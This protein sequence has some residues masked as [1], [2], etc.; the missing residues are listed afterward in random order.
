[1]KLFSL[2]EEKKKEYLNNYKNEKIYEIQEI[3]AREREE[4]I[5]Y[6]YNKVNSSLNAFL[7]ITALFIL[8][9]NKKPNFL[10]SKSNYNFKEEIKNEKIEII[11][12]TLNYFLDLENINNLELENL[13]QIFIFHLYTM[14]NYKKIKFLFENIEESELE[15]NLFEKNLKENF[16]HIIFDEYNDKKENKKKYKIFTLEEIKNISKKPSINIFESKI[17]KISDKKSSNIFNSIFNNEKIVIHKIFFEKYDEII[18]YE[19]KK[20]IT[21]TKKE[22]SS[23]DYLNSYITK[24]NQIINMNEFEDS[25]LDELII[26]IQI[27]VKEN[28]N[29]NNIN[30]NKEKIIWKNEKEKEK[31]FSFIE[32]QKNDRENKSIKNEINE[33]KISLS[34]IEKEL[35]N[36]RIIN[37]KLKEEINFLKKELDEMKNKYNNKEEIINDLKKQLNEEKINNNDLEKKLKEKIPENLK[38]LYELIFEKDKEISKLKNQLKKFPFKLNK[39]EKLISI[40]ITTFDED[41]SY[42]MICKNTDLFYKIEKEF[43]K[44]YGEYSKANN[45]FI[46]KNNIINKSKSLLENKI[47][48]HDQIILKKEKD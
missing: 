32:G 17:Q 8:F 14:I 1:M 34:K 47:Y 6:N 37:N 27:K 28:I 33:E 42:S 10:L 15:F 30:E 18:R 7:F 38:E 21:E 29:K 25:Y 16:I 23:K 3:C 5:D 11:Q 41:I 46:C 44:K 24:Y 13:K 2:S 39:E 43:Y 45:I 35:D 4:K 19:I 9:T 48:N 36:E 20:E 22:Y 26:N 31:E 40:I 12:N